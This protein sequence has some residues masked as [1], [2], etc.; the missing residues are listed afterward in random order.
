MKLKG[1]ADGTEAP[2]VDVGREQRLSDSRSHVKEFERRS[3]EN[4]PCMT[5]KRVGSLAHCLIM[6]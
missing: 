3:L 1:S 5:Q 2:N 4:S 6:A